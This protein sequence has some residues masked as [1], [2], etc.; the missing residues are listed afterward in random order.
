MALLLMGVQGRIAEMLIERLLRQRDEVRVLENDKELADQWKSMGAHVAQGSYDDVDLID[1]ASTNVR[2]IVVGAP[3]DDALE[4]RVA[5]VDEA[6]GP[7][8]HETR[9]VLLGTKRDRRIQ[10]RLDRSSYEYVYLIMRG[11]FRFG[12]GRGAPDVV[13]EA[14]D[15]ADDMAGHPRLVVELGDPGDLRLLG[16]GD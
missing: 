2:T 10:A 5:A 8:S 12:R 11:R 16:I 14:I 1:R 4:E 7:R 3:D 13:A 9:L 15:A 6:V